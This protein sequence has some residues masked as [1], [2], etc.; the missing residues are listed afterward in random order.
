MAIIHELNLFSWKDFQ[1][2]LQNLGDLERLRLVIDTIPDAKLMGILKTLRGNGR[3][4][5]P[6]EAVWNSILAGIVY[7]HVSIESLRRELSRNAQ[8]REIC[9]FN[10]ISG[11]KGVPSKSAYNRFLS[12]LVH[13][14]VLVREMFDN[15]VTELSILVPG[16]GTNYAGDG[17]AIESLGNPPKKK[18]GDHRRE[19]DADWGVKKYQGIDGNGKPWEKIK[20]WFGF[21]LHVIVDADAEL[22]IAYKVT[23]ASEGEGPVM[24]ELFVELEE[25]HPELIKQCE[26]AMF[27]KGRRFKSE[28]QQM[29]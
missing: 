7:E 2:D 27:D 20:S 11:V 1:E 19:E 3:N 22:P 29:N 5:H 9:G 21:R 14:E 17:K 24:D 6:I 23:K 26:H 8:L 13:Q 4:D 28:V 12:N 25:K 15:L 18:D 10:P 16:F